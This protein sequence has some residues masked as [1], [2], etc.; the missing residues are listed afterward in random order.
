MRLKAR[1]RLAAVATG[2]LVAAG[3]TLPGGA[4]HA[5]P[6]CDVVYATNDWNTGF[7]ANVTVTNLGDPVTSWTLTF[8]FPG[9]QRITQGWSANWSQSGNRVTATNMS[10]NGNLG[11]GAST[12]IGFNGAYSGTN[13]KPTSFAVN[14]VTCGGIGQPQPPTVSLT[15]PAGPFEAPA[16]V[17]LTAT[18]SDPD[19]TIAKVEFYRNGLLVNTDTSAPYSYL[20]E[21]LPAGAYTVQA[22]AYDNANL[23]ATAER[24]FTV[25]PASGPVSG[26]H[27]VLGQRGRGE[28]LHGEPEAQRRPGRQRAGHPDPDRGHR[29]HRHPDLGRADPDHL[30]HRREPH[31]LGG[32][33]R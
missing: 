3:L 26:S 8:D 15:V 2:V 28:Q 11:T 32:R 14:G 17:P 31:H 19:G 25:T 33:G 23:T 18:A 6:S 9:N 24:A 7:T 4:A 12:A 16:D 30:E 5:A 22:K 1:R 21:D 29:R 10:Y 27:P 13:A 20:L